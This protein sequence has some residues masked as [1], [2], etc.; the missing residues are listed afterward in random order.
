M[1]IQILH[2]LLFLFIS[3]SKIIWKD[4]VKL[5]WEDF[6][7]PAKVDDTHDA[8][9]WTGFQY[10][11]AG[12]YDE[13]SIKLDVSVVTTFDK[14]KSWVKPEKKSEKLLQH[15]QLHFDISE[16]IARQIRRELIEYE[17]TRDF[18]AEIQQI[19]KNYEKLRAD[20]QDQYD[21][22]T[23]HSMNEKEQ[24]Q[25]EKKIA[26]KIKNLNDYRHTDFTIEAELK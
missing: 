18:Q 15:E 16:Y 26:R 25:W 13:N 24:D 14:S 9:S 7:A 11:Y 4:D 17:F 12:E 23:N 6:Q 22:E 5:T 8:Q 19:Q 20:L 10:N 3:D 21:R 2:I 1:M